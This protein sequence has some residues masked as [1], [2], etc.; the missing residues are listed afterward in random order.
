MFDIAELE[1]K[2]RYHIRDAVR[3]DNNRTRQ[4]FMRAQQVEKKYAIQ[5]RKIARHCGDIIKGFPPGD[6]A[7]LPQLNASLRRY[8]EM[9][10]PWARFTAGKIVMEVARWD[11]RAWTT[12]S[13]QMAEGI[14]ADLRQ[15]NIGPV[16]RQLQ[17]EQIALIQSIPVIAAQRVHDL[18][19][20][21]LS[22]SERASEIAKEIMNSGS[23]AQSRAEL[24][25]RTEVARARTSFTQVRAETVGSTHYVWEAVMDS[26][27]RD[28]HRKLNGKTFAWNNPP[29]SGEK[30]ERSHPGAIYNC[31]CWPRPIF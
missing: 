28:L 16:Y 6:P 1:A 14:R 30:G 4:L 13:K 26:R 10:E 3:R 31:R 23:V 17:L 24:I 15:A 12:Y 21:A 22:G 20:E 25:A 7:A 29:V 8:S 27:T 9:L 2:H 18:T 11:E 19:M 5:L